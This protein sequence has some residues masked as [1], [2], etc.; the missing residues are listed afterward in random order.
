M[1]CALLSPDDPDPRAVVTDIH[2]T[3][4]PPVVLDFLR[5]EEA[6]ATALKTTAR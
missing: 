1:S 3:R 2:L 6:A 4:D 5:G